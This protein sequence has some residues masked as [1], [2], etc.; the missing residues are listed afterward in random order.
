MHTRKLGSSGSKGRLHRHCPQ[1]PG[2]SVGTARMIR[3]STEQPVRAAALL[4]LDSA[5]GDSLT[6]PESESLAW[7]AAVNLEPFKFMNPGRHGQRSCHW[8]SEA[9]HL[10][11]G[12]DSNQVTRS[13]AVGLGGEARPALAF[14]T[15]DGILLVLLVGCRLGELWCAPY[16]IGT[17]CEPGFEH[18]TFLR[19]FGLF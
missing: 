7:Q 8:H 2:S 13:V 17:V 12:R 18:S 9:W 6:R 14:S 11:V 1:C 16:L 3:T 10:R 19:S 5:A 15:I 4:R